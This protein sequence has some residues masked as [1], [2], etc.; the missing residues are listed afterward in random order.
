MAILHG[1]RFISS[2]ILLT[3][4]HALWNILHKISFIYRSIFYTFTYYEIYSIP[5]VIL[6]ARSHAPFPW[7]CSISMAMLHTRSHALFPW[8][9]FILEAILHIHSH[10]LY[11]WP[12]LYSMPILYAHGHALYSKPCSIPMAIL[13]TRSHTLFPWP[14]FMLEAILYKISFIYRLIIHAFTYHKIYSMPI[15]IS[16]PHKN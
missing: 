3:Q 12:Y 1:L 8:P 11:P 4:I 15:A 7:P 10:A 14:Y 5:I 13:H 6:H 2:L 16:M 9:C